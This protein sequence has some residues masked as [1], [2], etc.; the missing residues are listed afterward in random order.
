LHPS[1]IVAY[2]LLHGNS[3]SDPYIPPDCH[4]SALLGHQQKFEKRMAQVDSRWREEVISMYA[5]PLISQHML[6]QKNESSH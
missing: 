5:G 2:R 6:D 1:N 4:A 3:D